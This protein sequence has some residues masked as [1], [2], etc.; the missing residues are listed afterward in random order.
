MEIIIY[1]IMRSISKRPPHCSI[2]SVFR[3]WTDWKT[4]TVAAPHSVAKT[5]IHLMALGWILTLVAPMITATM[6][7]TI[8]LVSFTGVRIYLSFIY[9]IVE[10]GCVFEWSIIQEHKL[11]E[12]LLH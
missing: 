3:F 10:W 11:L 9:F 7:P 1:E 6:C 12:L 4:I 5:S 2:L 8:P